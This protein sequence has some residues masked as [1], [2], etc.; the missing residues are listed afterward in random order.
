MAVTLSMLPEPRQ[1]QRG[2]REP[3][4]VVRELNKFF[5]RHRG[6]HPEAVEFF[7]E[8][9]DNLLILDACRYDTFK[10]RAGLPGVLEKRV[11]RSSSTPA[12]L[13]EYIDGAD[14]RDTVYV[15]ANPQLYKREEELDVDLYAV[16]NVWESESWDEEFST[17]RPEAVAKVAQEAQAEYPNKRLLV[18]FI[19][20]HYPFIGP[21]GQEYFDL[22]T[23]HFWNRVMTG[24]V[25]VPADVLRQAYE[26]NLD[27]ALPVIEELL[28]D[29]QGLTVVSSDH[30]Q[31]FGE[32]A[33]PIPMAEFGHPGGILTEELVTVPWLEYQNGQRRTITAGDAVEEVDDTDTDVE[34]RLEHL[35]YR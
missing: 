8:D 15:T 13:Y 14:L 31:M 24:K 6:P 18:H 3:Y 25:D 19:Q 4:L 2:L 1:I 35:G 20:P 12:F 22:T 21:T 11:T 9:W 34:K 16:I 5:Y 10:E 33:W 7:E 29:L 26:E 32:R 17:V 27:I 28:K 30:G 23:L